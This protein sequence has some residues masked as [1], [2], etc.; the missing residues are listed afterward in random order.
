VREAQIMTGE[1]KI[2]GICGMRKKAINFMEPL[3]LALPPPFT[4]ITKRIFS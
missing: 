1:G 4:R 2:S 3:A